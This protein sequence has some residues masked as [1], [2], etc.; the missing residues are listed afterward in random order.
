[1]KKDGIIRPS[2]SPWSSPVVL[3]K[4]KS[5]EFRFCVDYRKLNAVIKRDVYPLIEDVIDRLAG[6]NFFS[7][8]DLTSGY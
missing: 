7:S 6:A 8:L 5:E 3:V 4:K 1:M 2:S